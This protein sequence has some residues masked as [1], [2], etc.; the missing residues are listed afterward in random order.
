[1][2]VL[3]DNLYAW[4]EEFDTNTILQAEKL[5]RL[6]ILAGPVALMP[7]AHVGMGATVGSVIATKN[8]IIPAAV[9][10]DLGCGMIA[11]RTSLMSEDLPEDLDKFMPE[12]ERSIPAGVGRGHSEATKGASEWF[13]KHGIPGSLDTKQKKTAMTQMGSLG[14]G[15][16]FFEVCLDESDKVW[17][18]L[19][20][21]SRGVGNTLAQN[22]IRIAKSDFKSWVSGEYDLEDK[23]LAWFIEETPQFDAYISDMLWSQDYALANRNLM[24]QSVLKNF[25]NFVG[26]GKVEQEINC[27]HNFCQRETHGDHSVW[28]TRKGAIQAKDTDWGVIPGSMG[29]ETYIVKGTGNPL[30][31]NSCSHGAGRTMSRSKAKTLF[32][33]EDLV[34]LMGDRVWN[35]D[36][37]AALIDEIPLSYKDI[38]KVMEAQ[39]DLVEVQYKLH[40]ILNYKGQ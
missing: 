36:S 16:H 29:A 33:K 20:S 12:V 24:M 2:E 31:W 11:I 27:H 14:S 28:V 8:A 6:P 21:G 30:S 40:Q 37:A 39:K 3:N 7:D 13:D 22:H 17:L 32:T 23:D 4:V 35:K 38:N 15:N 9:G 25:F 19:H 1:M 26:T 18:V 5:S 34:E 10:V